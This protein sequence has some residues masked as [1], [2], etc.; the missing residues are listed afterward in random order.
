MP[1]D[2]QRRRDTFRKLGRRLTKLSRDP[3][4]ENVHGFRI[5]S[6]RVET[7]LEELTLK[8]G[9]N[10]KKLLKLLSGLRKKA[11]HV[12]DL[13]AQIIA[14][15]SLKIPQDAER[16]TQLLR[17][18]IEE[19]S[20]RED[21]L[22]KA[23]DRPTVAEVRER[24]KRA[25]T[26][27]AEPAQMDTL[28]LAMQRVEQLIAERGPI[29]E[30]TLHRYRI[31]G[32]RARYLA[33]LAGKDP[34]AAQFIAQLKRMQDSLGD[35]HDWLQLTARAEQSFPDAPGSALLAA[36]HN[37]TRAK[38]RQAIQALIETRTALAVKPTTTSGKRTASL[39]KPPAQPSAA[40]A[41]VA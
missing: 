8:P 15:R 40:T 6:R 14:L 37:V 21:K 28:S 38:F 18:L 35:W 41:A 16:R 27:L 5:C 32:K 13:D 34:A 7:M 24:L 2:Q 26:R 10:K 39:P 1:I 3:A 9:R 4:A 20:K 19:R 29:T 33:E 22:A 25:A 31:V 17:T 12:R 36:L 30:K 11:G 23:F